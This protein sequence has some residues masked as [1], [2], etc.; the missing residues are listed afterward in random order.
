MWLYDEKLTRSLLVSTI[1]GWIFS[2]GSIVVLYILGAQWFVVLAFGLAVVSLDVLETVR[3]ITYSKGFFISDFELVLPGV[4]KRRFS[5]QELEKIIL[6][7]PS[8]G[9]RCWATFV[10]KKSFTQCDVFVF[11]K[12]TENCGAGLGVLSAGAGDRQICET[13]VNQS[14]ISFNFCCAFT[15]ELITLSMDSNFSL[16]LCKT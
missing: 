1:T 12:E 7:K 8:G 5:G 14:R 4:G 6:P 13:A 16:A 9:G 2:I 11:G 15:T 3:Y 10:F